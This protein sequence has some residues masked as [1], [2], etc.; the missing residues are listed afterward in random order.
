MPTFAPLEAAF[1]KSPAPQLIVKGLRILRANAAAGR[2][3]GFDEGEQALA[4]LSLEELFAAPELP[5]EAPSQPVPLRALRPESVPALKAT[6][7]PL[8]G[9]A[10]LWQLEECPGAAAGR[11]EKALESSSCELD[12][13]SAQIPGVYF[14]LLLDEQ[15]SPSFAYISEKIEGLIGVSADDARKD[16]SLVVGAIA[17]EDLERAHESLAAAASA[18][19]PLH[20]EF[21][22]AS[23][24]GR[25]RWVAMKAT[26]ERRDDSSVIMHGIL[27]DITLRKESEERLRM[28]SAAVDVSSDFALM[29]DQEGRGLY[30]NEAFSNILGY[31]SVDQLNEA[32]G[33]VALFADRTPFD[34]IMRESREGGRWQ[35]DVRLLS[36]TGE[37]L[38][39][40][41]RAVAI[42]DEKGRLSAIVA[43]GT[44]VT[45][46]KRRQELLQRFNS[47]LRAQSEASSD[48]ILVIDEQGRICNY[49][50][51]LCEIWGAE[52]QAL[53]DGDLGKVLLAAARRV[54]DPRGFV[55]GALAAR[56]EGQG[57]TKDVVRFRDGRVFE[58]ISAP[59]A[60]T[61]GEAYGRVW[62]FHEITEQVKSEDRLV[63]AMKE[64]EEASRA[65]S[66]FLAN[67]SHEIRTPMNGIIGMTGLLLDT[68]LAP[69]QRDYLKTIQAS[70]EA[71]LVVINDILD[72]SKIESG[73]LEIESIMF[74]L[75]E[76]IEEAVDTL[77]L[78]A[79][80]KGLELAYTYDPSLSSAVVGDPTRL[81]QIIVNLLGNAIK[82]TEEGGVMMRV[83]A[84]RSGEDEI[85]LQFSVSDTGIGIPKDR[86]DSLFTSFSQVDPSTT[87]KYGGTGLGL[88]ICKNLVGLMGGE[89]RV[90]S[91]VDAGSTFYFTIVFHK[92]AFDFR[93]GNPLSKNLFE[94]RVASLVES[95]PFNRQALASQL[96]ALG[97]EAEPYASIEEAMSRLQEANAPNLVFLDANLVS[98]NE[99]PLDCVE[100][101]REAAS[102]PELPIALICSLGSRLSPERETP[103]LYKLLRPYKLAAVKKIAL[104]A[105]EPPAAPAAPDSQASPAPRKRLNLS[106]LLAEDNAINQKLASRLFAKLGY[107]ID[108]ADD[109]AK[110][111][112]M[113]E[114]KRYDLVFMDI[115]MPVMDGLEATRRIRERNGP[116]EPCIIALT[117]NAMRE[118]RDK[119]IQAGMDD[120]LTKPFKPDDLKEIIA[121]TFLKLH[122]DQAANVM[123][124]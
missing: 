67:M 48:G 37:T 55:R 42:G 90:E 79:A 35:G 14:H 86:L 4:G 91:E 106:I 124:A 103:R 31:Q 30:F 5:L 101:L 1:S 2:L 58:R 94:G 70:S 72:F 57:Q 9:D 26:P 19:A 105:L 116:R 45:S 29:M 97:L 119:C 34:G 22:M 99:D 23:V 92:A 3:L 43:M 118:D 59:I 33:A 50:R 27:E 44:D 53:D 120:F 108:L 32:G 75:R 40:F 11:A 46:S 113:V 82:F 17:V 78:Q 65:K 12:R 93:F 96:A 80:E 110:A 6:S 25:L 95:H 16:A 109:G 115:Q 20:I 66:Y 104:E 61:S 7:T 41:F 64:A 102:S 15:G 122:P 60:P 62:F 51:R 107:D 85:E 88:A 39:I 121:K 63:K 114:R 111:L 47:V 54:E 28:V 123:D 10:F 74:D 24:H 117:A 98:A 13:L 81:R 100:K 18:L 112:E 77:A 49:N 68:E 36:R 38:D 89:M 8:E 83:E 69:E 56:I 52:P 76:C 71:L 73:K 87:R 21:R 84:L